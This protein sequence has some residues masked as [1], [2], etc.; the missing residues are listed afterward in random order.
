MKKLTQLALGFLLLVLAAGSTGCEAIAAQLTSPAER[1]RQEGER[2]LLEERTA[3]AILALRAAADLDAGNLAAVKHLS[4]LYAAQGRLRLALR[5][6]ARSR[7]QVPQDGELP[8]L[9]EQYSQTLKSSLITA[10][11]WAADLGESEPVGFCTAAGKI[12]ITLND[13]SVL[14]IRPTDGAVLW[15]VKLPSP[16]TSA[17]AASTDQL[18]V[19]AQ[20]GQLYALSADTGALLWKF[21]TRAPIYAPPAAG[22]TT[23][24]LA[25]GD[26]SFYA[27]ERAGGTQ[28]W[29]FSS[30]AGLHAQPTLANEVVYFGSNDGHLYALNAVSGQPHWATGILTQG[31]VESQAVIADG[32]VYIGSS[33]S[34]VYAL[35]V[36][37]GGE[38]W[39]FSTPDAVYAAPL[40]TDEAV[41]VASAGGTLT[42][43]D[44]TTGKSIWG[45]K[46]AGPLSF[47][48][49]YTHQKLYFVTLGKPTLFAVDARTGAAISEINTGDWFAAEPLVLDNTLYLLSKAGY[50][51]AYAI[52]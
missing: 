27:L 37:S 2:L 7:A 28:R 5:M 10:P 22:D 38:Y 20:D 13:G 45:I 50:L 36:A 29:S 11:L 14:A 24:Y 43:L 40:V 41:F 46:T 19:G 39:R 18:W 32:R 52:Q 33:D 31:A 25:S 9:S 17:P 44:K 26:G 35:A 23:L 34:R 3:E 21:S 47:P 12:F 4:Q 6:L 48:P 51:L 15:R 8:R 30:G 42:S 49:V 16:A 1:Y